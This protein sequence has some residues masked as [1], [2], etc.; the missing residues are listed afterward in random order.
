MCI[1]IKWIE[2]SLFYKIKMAQI[3]IYGRSTFVSELKKSISDAMHE[4]TVNILGLPQEK[5]FHRFF[6]LKDED[7]VHPDDRSGKY[8]ILE[9][10][11]I[12]GRSKETKKNYIRGLIMVLNEKCSIPVND[13]EITLL[14]NPKENWGIRGMPADELKL[15]YK[16]EK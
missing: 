14:E 13:I 2:L 15:N 3:K 9:I 7:F 12:S 6:E 10:S 11:I 8:L 4:C 1:C 16:V 5:R